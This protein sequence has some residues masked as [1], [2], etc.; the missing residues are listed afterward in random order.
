MGFHPLKGPAAA[1]DS[2]P[3]SKADGR[4]DTCLACV[5]V[6]VQVYSGFPGELA[7]LEPDGC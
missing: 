5:A 6:E 7:G 4:D 2:F 3:H 1:T